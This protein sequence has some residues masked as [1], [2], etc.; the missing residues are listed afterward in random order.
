MPPRKMD[1]ADES[2]GDCTKRS[3]NHDNRQG[4]PTRGEIHT[5]Q[6]SA[7]PADALVNGGKVR[8][9][10]ADQDIVNGRK[11]QTDNNLKANRKS[12]SLKLRRRTQKTHER[13]PLIIKE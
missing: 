4:R 1:R 9:L 7:N 6:R 12:Y 2:G 5:G 13:P 10:E 8:F 3:R 11:P